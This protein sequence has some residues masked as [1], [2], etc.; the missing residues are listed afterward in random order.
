MGSDLLIPSYHTIPRPN[1][2][3]HVIPAQ[4]IA[5]R[6]EGCEYLLSSIRWRHSTECPASLSW[7]STRMGY[8]PPH[9]APPPLHPTSNQTSPP[10]VICS[11]SS[12]QVMENP[13]CQLTADSTALSSVDLGSPCFKDESY[14]WPKYSRIN[15]MYPQSSCI[16]V[17]CYVLSGLNALRVSATNM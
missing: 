4:C 6:R 14:C 5:P 16:C 2:A 17:S 8:N 1:L 7:V 11:F 13:W 12:A 9:P 3:Y 10:P 15:P